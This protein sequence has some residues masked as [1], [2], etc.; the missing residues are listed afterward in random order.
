[1]EGA[2]IG[3]EREQKQRGVGSMNRKDGGVGR[4]TGVGGAGLKMWR[5]P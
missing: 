5:E 3:G 1:M 2:E 4:N